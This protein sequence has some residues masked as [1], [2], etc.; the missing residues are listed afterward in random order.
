MIKQGV[1]TVALHLDTGLF[2][3]GTPLKKTK[4]AIKL[5]EKKTG[6]KIPLRVISHAKVQKDRIYCHRDTMRAASPFHSV[7]L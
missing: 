5:L 4:E 1:N 3:D 7:P 6:K 2:S